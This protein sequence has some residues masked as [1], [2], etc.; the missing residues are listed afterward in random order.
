[1]TPTS[2]EFMTIAEI[3]TRFRVSEMSVRR[4][5]TRGEIRAIQFGRQWRIPSEAVDNK[6]EAAL[7]AADAAAAAIVMNMAAKEAVASVLAADAAIA[8]AD[9]AQVGME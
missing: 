9:K 5:I 6:V 4:M 7:L 1:M 3:A 2:P 8:A